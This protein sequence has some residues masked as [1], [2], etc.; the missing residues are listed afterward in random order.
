MPKVHAWREEAPFHTLTAWGRGGR[1]EQRG[2]W[3]WRTAGL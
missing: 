3:D 2:Q 1:C